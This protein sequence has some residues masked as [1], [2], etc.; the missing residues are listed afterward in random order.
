MIEPL[1]MILTPNLRKISRKCI[2][3]RINDIIY[4]ICSFLAK[5]RVR[6]K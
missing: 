1:A 4:V 6:K 3:F 2:K 5:C